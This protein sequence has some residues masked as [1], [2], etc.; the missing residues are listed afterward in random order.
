PVIQWHSGA[1][2]SAGASHS[3]GAPTVRIGVFTYGIEGERVTGIARYTGELTR[4]LRRLDPSLELMLLNPYPQSEHPWYQ[5]FPTHPMPALARL[6]L[7]ATAGNW[8]LHRAAVRL[9]LDILHDPC[10]IA[11]FAWP[12]GRSQYARVTTVHDAIPA[13]YPETQP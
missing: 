2:Q 3:N 4:A 13:V 5:E 1:H 8:Q 12:R 11:P 7:A 10:G 9:K 6:P